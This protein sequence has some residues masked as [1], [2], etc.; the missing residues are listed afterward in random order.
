MRNGAATLLVASGLFAG[1]AS[2][3]LRYEARLPANFAEAAAEREVAIAGFSGPEAGWYASQ[4]EA[5]LAGATL[6]GLPWFRVSAAGPMAPA[7]YS[8]TV[9]IDDV[10]THDW[11]ETDRE[12]VEW[13]GLF[14]CERRADVEKL[15]VEIDVDV[16]VQLRLAKAPDGALV[17]TEAYSSDADDTICETLGEVG[18]HGRGRA[19]LWR[20]DDELRDTERELVREALLD[21]LDDIRRDIAPRNAVVKAPLVAEALDPVARADPMFKQAV[22]LAEDGNVPAAC[23]SWEALHAA[24]PDAPGVTHNLGACAEAAGDYARAQ[25][26]YAA[27]VEALPVGGAALDGADAI[28]S[29]LERINARRDGDVLIDRL[30]GGS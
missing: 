15:C 7:V 14:D 27:A 9:W 2:P 8:G 6:D 18:R 12:C 30:S 16:T 4:F 24:Y 21:T 1:C 26:L 25:A 11:I 23:A 13:D 3:A 10:D 5:M 17:F 22:K 29:S 28:F 20:L 19:S